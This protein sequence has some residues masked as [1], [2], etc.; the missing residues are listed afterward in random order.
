MTQVFHPSW[1]EICRVIQQQFWTKECDI[2]GVKT[3]SDP[4]YIFSGVRTPSTHDL[5]P[6]TRDLISTDLELFDGVQGEVRDG[7]RQLADSSHNHVLL[8][9]Q[10]SATSVTCTVLIMPPPLIGGALSDAFVDVWRVTFVWRLSVAYI[11]RN[12]RTER[13]RKTK[14]GTEI[15]RV[16][17]MTRTPLSRSKG[18][19]SRSPGRF[20]QPGLNVQ[21]GSSGQPGNVFS[22]GKFCYVASARRRARR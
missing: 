3:Y 22:V 18:Q 15:A 2:L 11:G 19:R 1:C 6:C 5:R 17:H 12:S 14:I 10:P 13:A 7:S 21:R 16:S 4:S 8:V 9:L 20:T